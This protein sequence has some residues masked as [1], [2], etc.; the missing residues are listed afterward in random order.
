M[1]FLCHFFAC[2]FLA[3]GKSDPQNSWLS[4]VDKYSSH[5]DYD[6]NNQMSNCS[7]SQE[8]AFSFYWSLATTSSVGYGD[9]T[10]YNE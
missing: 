1:I 3:I 2:V 6:S 10:P 7:L 4:H 9:I 5:C 8:Y